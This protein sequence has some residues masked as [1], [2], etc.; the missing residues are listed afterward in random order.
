MNYE[1]H[2]EAARTFPSAAEILSE[3]GMGM[4][5]AEMVWGAAV[6][7]IDAVNHRNKRK[8]QKTEPPS[9]VFIRIKI[10]KF[11]GI[12][13]TSLRPACAFRHNLKADNTGGAL[14]VR[15]CAS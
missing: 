2:V 1:D 9:R 15:R 3:S 10:Y 8:T 13:M 12:Y 4:A 5:A 11:G 7:A 6:Q 14:A